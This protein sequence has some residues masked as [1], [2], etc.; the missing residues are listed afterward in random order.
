[1]SPAGVGASTHHHGAGGGGGDGGG[2]G[3]R[4]VVAIHDHYTSVLLARYPFCCIHIWLNNSC[5][6]FPALVLSFN[7]S[8]GASAIHDS[9]FPSVDLTWH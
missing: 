2:G 1:M 3:G 4:G 7:I 5:Y 9:G 6:L 8:S